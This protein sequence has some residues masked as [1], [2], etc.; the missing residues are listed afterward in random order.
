[1][2]NNEKQ[3]AR[4]ATPAES[5]KPYTVKGAVFSGGT[6]YPV[7]AEIALTDAEAAEMA[8]YVTPGKPKPAD[9]I[10]KRRAGK[11]RVAKERNLFVAGGLVGQGF[12]LDLDEVEAR[13]LGDA[14]EPA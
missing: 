11:Y 12:E 6:A 9:V 1:M 13:K 3:P 5:R 14:I 4:E 2:A 10:A 7:G 8:E